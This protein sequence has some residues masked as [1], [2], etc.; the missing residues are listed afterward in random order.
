MKVQRVGS[1]AI[2]NQLTG[3]IKEQNMNRLQGKYALIT[4]ASQGLGRQLAIDFARE[5]AAGISIVARNVECL[6]QVRKDIHEIA[7]KTQ[8]LIIGAD[9]TKHED[10]ERVVATTLCE[11]NGHLD[12]L[13]NNAS[14]IGPSPMP[15]LLDYPLEDFRNVINTNLIAPFLL[16]KKALPAMIENGGSIINVT[17]DAGVNGYPGWGA[18]G[19][20]KFGIEG[21]SQTWA[22]ELEDS[23]VRVNWVDPG[24]MNT[25]MHRA[26]EPEEDPTQWANPAD[27]TEVFIYLASDESR[28]VNG[29]RFQAQEE[30]WGQ[31]T[32]EPA[33]V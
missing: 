32:E 8:V 20:S 21:M 5:A 28:H 29:Q 25:A 7:P 26:A 11:F 16:I 2:A 10:I 18:Y 13:V 19:I 27:V 3:N 14:S 12:I 33:L 31:E 22:A 6:N 9:L 30:N 4:G 15:Y 23:G 24:D 1:S 17:S